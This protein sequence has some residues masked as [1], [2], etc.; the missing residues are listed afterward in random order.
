MIIK[1][2]EKAP[3]EWRERKNALKR[4]VVARAKYDAAREA[5]SAYLQEGIQ[6]DVSLKTRAGKMYAA[7]L[8]WEKTRGGIHPPPMS[9]RAF[10]L[11]IR[12]YFPVKKGP[13][14]IIFYVGVGPK[15]VVSEVA[16]VGGGS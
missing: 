13:G 1:A 10:G 12:K 8:E 5:F 9:Q 6:K 11:R 15:A 2:G 4:G 14:G 16:A 7:Y 3:A